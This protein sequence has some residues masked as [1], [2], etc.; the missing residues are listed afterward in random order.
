MISQDIENVR[1]VLDALR[2]DPEDYAEKLGA[3]VAVLE[4]AARDVRAIET[5][6]IPLATVYD[7]KGIGRGAVHIRPQAPSIAG[8][9]ALPVQP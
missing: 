2:L 6:S 4:A 7:L 1:R 5:N 8:A 3:A 9:E